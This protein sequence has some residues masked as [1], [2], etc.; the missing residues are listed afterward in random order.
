[1]ATGAHARTHTHM[2]LSVRKY[3]L[4]HLGQIEENICPHQRDL[5]NRLINT[6]AH[7]HTHTS[8]RAQTHTHR[9]N[10]MSLLK[11]CVHVWQELQHWFF[12][13]SRLGRN[14][15]ER[16]SDVS[17]QSK[18]LT[19]RRWGVH[20]WKNSSATLQLCGWLG[21]G[22]KNELA[23]VTHWTY[24]VLSDQELITGEAQLFNIATSHWPHVQYLLRPCAGNLLFHHAADVCEL[25]HVTKK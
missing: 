25:L 12:S 9:Q 21:Q 22:C 6:H 16:E 15:Q 10:V 18:A 23:S 14:E 17:H 2:R 19:M 1:M 20:L 24:S 3:W 8:T 11:G 5:P 4:D 13:T 7:I